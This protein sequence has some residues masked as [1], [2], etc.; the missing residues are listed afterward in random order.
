MKRDIW[1]GS[2]YTFG[3]GGY[4][5]Q[6]GAAGLDAVSDYFRDE[7]TWSVKE[8]YTK[9]NLNAYLPRPLYSYKNEQ[10]Q[11]RYLQN[12][13]YIRLK[14]LQVGYTIP[15]TITSHWGIE[16]LRIFFSGE[17]L[18][19]GTGVKKQYD[20]ETIGYDPNNW[21]DYVGMSYP[22]SRT[23]SFGLNITL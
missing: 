8:G 10:T 22:L 17:N 14:N 6:W 16:N 11:T 7:N 9:P 15:A 12:A 2:V 4:N 18:W 5:G 13:A 1:N 23:L 3:A 20:P 21:S 19:T